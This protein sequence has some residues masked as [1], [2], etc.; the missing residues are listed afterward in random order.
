MGDRLALAVHLHTRCIF[1]TGAVA[2]VDQ[3]WDTGLYTNEVRS[4]IIK[5]EFAPSDYVEC[6]VVECW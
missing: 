5:N 6:R 3:L 1:Q 4:H 2:A